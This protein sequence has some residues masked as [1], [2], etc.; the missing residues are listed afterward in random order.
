MSKFCIG[1]IKNKR[2]PKKDMIRYVYEVVN[3]EGLEVFFQIQDAAPFLD[4]YEQ[5]SIV[6]SIADNHMYD[7]CEM[8]FLADDCYYNGKANN[9]PFIERMHN[10]NSIIQSLMDFGGDFDLFVGE[11]GALDSDFELIPLNK[12]IFEKQMELYQHSN[13]SFFPNIHFSKT[14][15]E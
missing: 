11:T 3:K 14:E 2:T 5:D 13:S 12:T 6:F 1:I 15:T 9:I 8:L 4:N 7:T 10:I